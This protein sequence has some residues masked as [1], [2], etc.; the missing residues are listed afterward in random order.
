MESEAA[1]TEFPTSTKTAD[2][3]ANEEEIREI[4]PKKEQDPQSLYDEGLALIKA[5]KTEKAIECLS[6]A[7]EIAT[8]QRGDLHESLYKFY[9]SYADAIIIQCE[10]EN[11]NNMF[12]DAVPQE[13]AK[14]E[15]PG[16]SAA[17]GDENDEQGS[18][19]GS[20]YSNSSSE[21]EA[22]QDSDK[23]QV[24][25]A[26]ETNPGAGPPKDTIEEK[27]GSE[28]SDEES[29]SEEQ[30]VPPPNQEEDLQ[31]AFENLDTARLILSRLQ[32]PDQEFLYKVQLRLGDLESMR[33]NF[34]GAC[35]E[36]TNALN[37]LKSMEG[38]KPTREQATVHYLIGLNYLYSKYKETEAAE[39]FKL[40]Y[41]ILESIL[42]TCKNEETEA[43]LKAV[44]EDLKIK[45]EDA[46]EQKESVEKLKEMENTETNV[47]DA[48]MM[49][50]VVDL[51][52]IKRK[53]QD[54]EIREENDD[55]KIS[56]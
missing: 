8:K 12:G 4:S 9:Y 22:P 54:D 28:C 35:V 56:N 19:S 5:E 46:L 7:L 25:P 15:E 3:P 6:N 2:L 53:K 55:K 11:S 40:S 13:V 44:M 52:V 43:E 1:H 34:D 18:E 51:G 30:N 21:A 20:E 47:F 27:E 37:L 45:I 32:T 38:L 41:A 49:T 29:E 14:S 16:N 48:P 17:E 24:D 31:L 23:M 42:L 39:N 36:Y 26:T 33:E 10:Q 50:N